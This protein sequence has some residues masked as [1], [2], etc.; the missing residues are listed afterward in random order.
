MD[1]RTQAT[2]STPDNDFVSWNL[3]AAN[4]TA[5]G[6]GQEKSRPR[7]HVI[8]ISDNSEVNSQSWLLEHQHL[9]PGG[10]NSQCDERVQEIQT[11]HTWTDYNEM[12]WV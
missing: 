12:D 1:A 11:G 9:V 4:M 7:H 8:C 2:C 3:G 5:C 10:Q 6:D